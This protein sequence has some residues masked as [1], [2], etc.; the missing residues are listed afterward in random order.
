MKRIDFLNNTQNLDSSSSE[1]GMTFFQKSLLLFG[2]KLITLIFTAVVFGFA[3]FN[4]TQKVFSENSSSTFVKAGADWYTQDISFSVSRNQ[5]AQSFLATPQAL[6]TPT[7]SPVPVKIES[8]SSDEI[9]E[10]L[11]DCESHKNWAANTGNGYYGGLQFS[12]GAWSSVG[13]IGLPS[14]HSRD[15]QIMRGKILQA[16]RGWGPWGNCSKKLGLL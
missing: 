9:W 2:E 3:F 10:K 14:E 4:L 16:K 7:P 11:A 13:G 1:Q 5:E 6:P 12:L 8:S 15:E